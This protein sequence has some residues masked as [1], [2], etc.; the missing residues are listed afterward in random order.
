MYYKIL[1]KDLLKH[2]RSVNYLAKR[3]MHLTQK[4]S[5]KYLHLTEDEPDAWRI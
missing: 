5:V 1:V 2:I 3:F 4:D